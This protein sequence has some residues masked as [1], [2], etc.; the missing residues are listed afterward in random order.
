MGWI[1]ARTG[2][3]GGRARSGPEAETAPVNSGTKWAVKVCGSKKNCPNNGR[4][5][6]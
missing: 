5:L 2:Q 1:V 3:C 4:I 6:T